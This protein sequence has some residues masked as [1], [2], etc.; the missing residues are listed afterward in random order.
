MEGIGRLRSF[1]GPAICRSS[2]AGLQYGSATAILDEIFSAQ[3][4]GTLARSL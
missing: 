3:P 2:E 4:D 1:E